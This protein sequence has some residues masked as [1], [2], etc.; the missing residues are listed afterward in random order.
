MQYLKIKGV[1]SEDSAAILVQVTCSQIHLAKGHTGRVDYCIVGVRIVFR[2]GYG[3]V[4]R[5][6][7]LVVTVLSS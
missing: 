2:S 3:S 5:L 1:D 6:R 7:T 4:P